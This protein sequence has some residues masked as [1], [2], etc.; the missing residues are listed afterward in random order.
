MI[1]R[2]RDYWQRL[3]KDVPSN[4]A[5]GLA[6]VA[7]L[8]ATLCV[9]GTGVSGTHGQARGTLLYWLLILP[10]AWWISGL[11]TF[12]PLYV[13]SWKP[14]LALAC[15]AGIACAVVSMRGGIGWTVQ[16]FG[17]IATVVA[18]ASS[19]LVYRHSL[20]AREGPAR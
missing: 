15:V 7:V 3:R 1:R 11:T 10:M 9:V 13:R 20:I 12:S 8:V 16:A 6:A 14:V 4:V 17:G 18:A 5:G 19:L 2:D